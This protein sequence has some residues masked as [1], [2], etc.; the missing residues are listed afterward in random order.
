MAKISEKRVQAEAT[1]PVELHEVFDQLIADYQ[2][3]A[4]QHVG[5][6]WV[7]YKILADLVREGWR[8]V[9]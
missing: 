2:S 3:S 6:V 9:S 5:K 1:L 8:K 7:N 4:E